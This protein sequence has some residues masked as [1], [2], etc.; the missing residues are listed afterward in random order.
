[1]FHF[2]LLN[3]RSLDAGNNVALTVNDRLDHDTW[4]PAFDHAVIAKIDCN[5]PDSVSTRLV[6]KD[7]IATLTFRIWN[8]LQV[9]VDPKAT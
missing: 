7:K 3:K 6:V 8:A 2:S 9:L 5:V 1:M 4:W